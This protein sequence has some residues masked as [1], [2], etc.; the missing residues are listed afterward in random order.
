MAS[1]D[2]SRVAELVEAELRRQMQKSPEY[3]PELLTEQ[4]ARELTV[5]I[6]E[7][8]KSMGVRTVIAIC[9]N[10]GN[11]KLLSRMDGAY[12]GSIAIAQE[13]AYTSA[14]LKMPTKTVGDEAVRGGALEGLHGNDFNRI[15]MLGGGEPL[16]KNG[17]VCGGLGVSG[18]TAEQDT[19]LAHFGAESYRR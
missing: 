14:A 9:D 10:G 7:K 17:I 2:A 19:F 15:S 5:K 11:L 16:I 3:P 8:A 13:K 18:G 4:D 12:I 1:I 6:E